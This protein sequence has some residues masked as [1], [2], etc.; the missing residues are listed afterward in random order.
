MPRADRMGFGGANHSLK[1]E[2]V[3]E[4]EPFFTFLRKGFGT[5]VEVSSAL[6]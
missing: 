3:K 2:I 4:W 5:F 1:T 6:N